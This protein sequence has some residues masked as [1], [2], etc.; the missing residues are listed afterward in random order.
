MT[1]LRTNSSLPHHPIPLLNRPIILV[2]QYDQSTTFNL[3]NISSQMLNEPQISVA[4]LNAPTTISPG[5]VLTTTTAIFF[6]ANG[7]IEGAQQH[8]TSPNSTSRIG[9]IDVLVCTSTVNLQISDCVVSH[10][11]V[12]DCSASDPNLIPGINSSTMGGVD[13]WIIHPDLVGIALS[14][15]P[16]IMPYT[17]VNSLPMFLSITPNLISSNL[18]PTTY[19]SLNT[20]SNGYYIPLDYISTAMFEVSM[21]GMVQGLLTTWQ[22][23]NPTSGSITSEFATSNFP[24]QLIIVII[25][26]LFSIS[27]TLLSTLPHSSRHA[28]EIDACR[29]IAIT[30]NHQLDEVFNGYSDRSV[31]IPKSVRETRVCYDV[32]RDGGKGG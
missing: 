21:R 23:Y 2:P 14:A 12:Q 4:Y 3:N 20:F 15:T 28:A 25:A 32:D 6:A 13:K 16:V 31:G 19:L 17:R 27:A 1:R 26:F 18:P 29:I 5:S 7:T 8:I 22:W 11:F 9:G 24:I 30:R 10:G